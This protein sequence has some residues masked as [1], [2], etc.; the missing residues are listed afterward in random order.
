MRLV[1]VQDL[2]VC[3]ATHSNVQVYA[4]VDI[5]KKKRIPIEPPD[6]GV[7]HFDCPTAGDEESS[8]I[9]GTRSVPVKHSHDIIPSVQTQRHEYSTVDLSKKNRN[10]IP[11][12]VHVEPQVNGVPDVSKHNVNLCEA[13]TGKDSNGI[14]TLLPVKHNTVIIVDPL[15]KGQVV[16]GSFILHRVEP[17]Y[18]G[19]VGGS[20][21]L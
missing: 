5:K 15:Y 9:A 13:D 18:K 21:L 19:Q 3:T 20:P 8:A 2:L 7:E 16:D 17:L 1:R 14:S 12:P 6:A 4:T 11:T 10:K